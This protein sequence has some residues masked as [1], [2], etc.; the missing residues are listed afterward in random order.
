MADATNYNYNDVLN[1]IQK[2]FS[3]QDNKDK[4]YKYIQG[5]RTTDNMVKLKDGSAVTIDQIEKG[6]VDYSKVELFL[7]NQTQ[8]VEEEMIE[9]EE[10]I[11]EIQEE[12]TTNPTL[13]DINEIIKTKNIEKLDS[14]LSTFAIDPKTGLVDIGRAIGIV[15]NNTIDEAVDAIKNKTEFSSDLS[16]YDVKGI[17]I[18]AQQ[19]TNNLNSGEIL[20]K[21]FNNILL[22]VEVAKLKDIVYSDRQILSAKQTYITQVQ[23][24]LNKLGLNQETQPRKEEVIEK[25]PDNKANSL[26]LKPDRDLK[27]A[28]FADIFILTVIVLVYAVIIINLI[29]KLK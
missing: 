16:N 3:N 4:Y 12:K 28:G 7:K 19:P 8:N 22:Y 11:E 6:E 17:K 2:Y 21:S 10:V 23:F 18:K 24:R 1:R 26:Q 15:T 9:E 14:I 25:E 20:N 5:I 13:N 29:M 27:K